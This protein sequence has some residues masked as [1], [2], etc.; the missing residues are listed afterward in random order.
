[1]R[2]PFPPNL[3]QNCSHLTSLIHYP[4]I[5]WQLWSLF[6]ST[7]QLHKT[8]LFFRFF[9]SLH[10]SVDTLPPPLFSPFSH[11]TTNSDSSISDFSFHFLY[12]SDKNKL[13]VSLNKGKKYWFNLCFD[14]SEWTSTSDTS[15][16]SGTSFLY[17][18]GVLFVF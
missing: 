18:R 8:L 12:C 11:S 17:W 7:C 10:S 9:F 13:W 6:F 4:L 2:H 1:M 16:L 15:L 5:Y 3:S 14:L